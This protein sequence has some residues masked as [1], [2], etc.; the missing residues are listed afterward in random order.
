[1]QG[2]I[3]TKTALQLDVL[4]QLNFTAACSFRGYPVSIQGAGVNA[5]DNPT[6]L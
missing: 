3:E 4:R 6:R 2:E 1:M 5:S